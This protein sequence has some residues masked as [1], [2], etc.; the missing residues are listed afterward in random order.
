MV[1]DQTPRSAAG[2]VLPPLDHIGIYKTDPAIPG[3]DLAGVF[4]PTDDTGGDTYDFVPCADGSLF[5]LMG[6]A[7]GHGIAG[8]SQRVGPARGHQRVAIACAERGRLCGDASGL[9]MGVHR[10][11]RACGAVVR[12]D[13]P[14][15]RP[16]AR[17]SHGGDGATELAVPRAHD[18]SLRTDPVALGKGSL[19]A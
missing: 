8:T 2:V 6:D 13:H 18:L 14:R 1:S 17:H 10:P 16:P 12:A 3:Y 11:R 7:T 19:A 4:L 9:A 15:A 5:L